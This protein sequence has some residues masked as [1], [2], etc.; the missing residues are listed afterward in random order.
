[1]HTE[2][3]NVN[4]TTNEPDEYRTFL[5]ITPKSV[6]KFLVLLM[7]FFILMDILR[8]IVKKFSPEAIG[9]NQTLD[10]LFKITGE[11]NLPTFFSSL[12][13]LVA[14]F[15][16]LVLGRV[17][18][19]GRFRFHW[20]FLGYVFIFLSLDESFMI[21]E[22]VSRLIRSNIEVEGSIRYG[23]WVVPYLILT[24]VLGLAYIRFLL[25]LPKKTKLL[26]ILAGVVFVTGAGVFELLEG[27][28]FMVAGEESFIYR[29][30]HW[31]QEML[32]MAGMII[33]IYGQL[34]YLV[35]NKIEIRF[36]DN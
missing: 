17:N 29:M 2:S 10:S 8:L 33:F 20:V 6:G 19:T 5:A 7:T 1:M 24:L 27:Y 15:L 35:S 36:R 3:D 18:R 11:Y 9:L 26:F 30:V 13:L 12:L 14:G 22:A 34:D 32:E 21:H 28:F 16:L 4:P 25:H 23:T 31:S